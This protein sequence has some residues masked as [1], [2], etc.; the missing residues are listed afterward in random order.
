MP[1]WMADYRFL[2]S[3]GNTSQMRVRYPELTAAELVTLVTSSAS[4]FQAVSDAALS[5]VKLS[6]SI[7]I[8]N[9]PQPAPGSSVR[10]VALLFYSNGEQ[11]SSIRLPAASLLPV[12]TSG[13]YSGFRITRGNLELS[14]LLET[15]EGMVQGALDPLGRPYGSTFVVGSRAEL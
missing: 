13:P 12:D 1:Q 5:G 10:T 11:V 14:A 4:L 7:A 6:K 9:P 8:V 2:D 15:V 3:N